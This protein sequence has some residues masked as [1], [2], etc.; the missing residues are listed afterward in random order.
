MTYKN[1]T[2]NKKMTKSG[3][4]EQDVKSEKQNNKSVEGFNKSI[5]RTLKW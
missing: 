1:R 5:Y 4:V 3:F 2:I